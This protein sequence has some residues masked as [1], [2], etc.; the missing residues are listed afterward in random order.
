MSALKEIPSSDFH[1]LLDELM[2]EHPNSVHVCSMLKTID[3]WRTSDSSNSAKIFALN[4][5]YRSKFIIFYIKPVNTPAIMASAYKWSHTEEDEPVVIDALRNCHEFPWSFVGKFQLSGLTKETSRVV[6]PVAKEKRDDCVD[7]EDDG[8]IFW[9]PRDD[10]MMTQIDIPEGKYLANL[11]KEHAKKINDV[12][13]HRFEGSVH[14]VECFLQFNVGVGL[15]DSETHELVAWALE[16]YHGGVGM[17]RTQENHL[18]KGYGAVVLKFITKEIANRGI[19]PHMVVNVNNIPS[20]SLAE[21]NN[22][23]MSFIWKWDDPVQK[24]NSSCSVR[25]NDARSVHVC[26]MLRTIDKWRTIDSSNSAKIFALNGDYRN[27]FILFYIKPANTQAIMA[28]AYKWSHRGTD[29]PVIIDALRN[30]HKFPWSFVGKFQFSALTEETARVV[31]PVVKEKRPDCYINDENGDYTFWM[32]KEDA[33]KLEIEIPAGTY[34]GNLTKCHAQKINDVWPHRFEGSVHLVECFL[35]FN[36]G[37]GLFDSQNDELMSWALAV[38]HGGVGMLK[39]QEHHLRK[40]YGSVVLKAITKRI[41]ERGENPHM[42]VDINNIPSQT[43]AKKLNYQ[44]AFRCRWVD[45]I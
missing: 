9:L 12:W 31:L 20:R 26:S 17:L 5:D 40:G 8:C 22:Y 45:N 23:Q 42:N 3:R 13:T 25:S 30:C 32:A 6:T 4:G 39:T 37:I 18:K 21:K 44:V 38:Y 1:S 28:S 16:V 43:L 24:W 7:K 34:L 27:K 35:Q 36:F 2:Q 10:A 15:F 19:N 41:A 29:E 14:L 11:T 33:Q